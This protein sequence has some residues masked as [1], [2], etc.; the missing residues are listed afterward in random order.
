MVED[1]TEILKLWNLGLIEECKEY[2]RQSQNTIGTLNRIREKYQD[3]WQ[4]AEGCREI[5]FYE[6]RAIQEEMNEIST[7]TA[8]TR[9]TT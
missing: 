4:I 6:Q 2:I 7:R 5:I 8:D 1:F 3:N 9:R